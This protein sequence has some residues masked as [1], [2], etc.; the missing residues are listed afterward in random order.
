MDMLVGVTTV[1]D[2]KAPPLGG[3]RIQ[4]FGS[5]AEKASWWDEHCGEVEQNLGDAIRGGALRSGW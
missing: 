5:K 3:T 2:P 4:K 1:S